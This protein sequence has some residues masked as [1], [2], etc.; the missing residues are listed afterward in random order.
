MITDRAKKYISG[1]LAPLLIYTLSGC[2]TFRN[3]GN[4]FKSFRTAAEDPVHEVF[5][6]DENK[7]L[8]PPAVNEA[9]QK[10]HNDESMHAIAHPYVIAN[11]N[12]AYF[13]GEVPEINNGTFAIPSINATYIDLDGNNDGK[14]DVLISYRCRNAAPDI[15]AIL[16]KYLPPAPEVDITPY[17]SQ[18]MLLFRGQDVK[19][20][21]NFGLISKLINNFDIDPKQIRIRLKIVE[22]FNDN[23]YDRDMALKIL[24]NGMSAF[25]LLLPSNPQGNPLT[26]G[27]SVDPFINKDRN[28]DFTIWGRAPNKWT[29]EGA[30]KFLDSHGR[31]E[32]LSDTD[33]VVSNGTTAEFRNVNAVPYQQTSLTPAA[34]IVIGT[35]YREVGP[36]LKLSP[37]TNEKGFTTIKLLEAKSGESIALVGKEQ[38]PVFRE[39]NLTSEFCLRNGTTYL[40][41]TSTNTRYKSV[42]RGIPGLN[43]IPLVR[44]AT[45]SREIEKNTSELLYFMEVF[46]I[47]RQ[48]SVGMQERIQEPSIA[49]LNSNPVKKE[50][51]ENKGF[52]KRLKR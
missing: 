46:D 43:K 42:N 12:R 11:N 23:T 3:F 45:T 9:T 25:N 33:V 44:G 34:A 4:E 47:E 21:E 28:G 32:T 31:T 51:S 13:K 22:Y 38:I 2:A 1:G 52:F 20:G 10:L 6:N 14:G 37:F 48:D 5:R 41:G 39:A 19:F 35:Q 40:I 29:Y 7:N 24:K 36:Q 49:E 17:L 16:A 27:I 18:N 50:K 30:I 8:E 15:A 26:T